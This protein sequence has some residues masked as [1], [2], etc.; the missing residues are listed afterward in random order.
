MTNPKINCVRGRTVEHPEHGPLIYLGPVLATRRKIFVRVVSGDGDVE[1]D[2]K[3]FDI[4][5]L[6]SS[7]RPKTRAKIALPDGLLQAVRD[8]IGEEGTH[9]DDPDWAEITTFENIHNFLFDVCQC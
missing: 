4:F 3:H 6:R 1:V 8:E 2:A 7:L 9:K 5:I